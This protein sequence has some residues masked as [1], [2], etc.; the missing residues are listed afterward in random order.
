MKRILLLFILLLN[1]WCVF[2]QSIKGFVLNKNTKKPVQECLV[3]IKGT[4]QSSI[5]NEKGVFEFVNIDNLQ[6]QTLVLTMLGY[7]TTEYKLTTYRKDTFYIT[8]KDVLLKE[9][10]ISANKKNILNPKNDESL[11]DF[12]LLNDGFVILTAGTPKNNLRLMDE[13][14]KVITSLKVNGKTET[15]KQDCI[16]NLQLLSNDS[17]WQVFYDYQ[18]L[19]ILNPHTRKYFEEVLGNCVCM[20]N[21]CYY[22]QTKAYRN[23]RTN[24]FYYTENEK[25]KRRELALFEDTSKIKNF[26][27]E[28][29]LQY[30]L[31]VR[32]QSNYTLY[33]EPVD[34]IMRKMEQYRTELPLDWA[35][36]HWLGE[37]ETQ[38]VKIDS[39]TFI[40]NFTDT[41][42]YDVTKNNELKFKNHPSVFRQKNVLPKT[43]IDGDYRETYLTKF[44]ES[45]LTIIKFN[46]HTGIEISRTAISNTPFLPKKIIIKN[47][48]AYFI[49]K[50]LADEQ[51]YKIIKYY[52]N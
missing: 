41:T 22:F 7:T 1:S 45:T 26:E 21:K 37:V 38:M 20:N 29:N 33:N 6:Q 48:N 24:Y 27:L 13:D 11:L 28:Y 44:E 52:L 35:Y 32:R 42:I 25:G 5:T 14:G 10:V 43:Y 2:S 4:T 31:D 12:E 16:G 23:L 51:S 39:N 17:A 40:V 49:Q 15:L 8:Q 47:G 18:N 36:I 34:A 50:N 9:V 19:N 46:I 30:F 3:I